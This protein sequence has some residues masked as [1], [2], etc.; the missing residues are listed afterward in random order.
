VTQ[1]GANGQEGG[2]SAPK[3][4]KV[5]Q[6]GQTAIRDSEALRTPSHSP[7]EETMTTNSKGLSLLV[8]RRHCLDC[9]GDSFKAVVWCPVTNCNLWPFR[10]GMNPATVQSK[11]GPGLVTPSMMPDPNANLDDLTNGIEA[12]AA[13]L[14]ERAEGA[15]GPGRSE[16]ATASSPDSTTR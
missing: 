5:S 6:V 11:Y 16:I 10:L 4:R 14:R 1:L 15:S 9:S 2:S 8:V 12:A 3:S 13:Y 7:T